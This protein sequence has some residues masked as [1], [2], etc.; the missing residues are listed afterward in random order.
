V[1]PTGVTPA[2]PGAE[3]STVEMC[4]GTA[5]ELVRLSAGT[6]T[7]SVLSFGATLVGLEASGADGEPGNC[8][9][10]LA[11]LGQLADPAVNPHLCG[12]VGPYA[13]RIAGASFDLDGVT[14]PLEANEGP[15]T[16]HGG[17]TPWDRR[18]W[19]IASLHAGDTEV[20][21]TLTLIDP[22]G[23]GGFPGRVEAT[24]TYS[25]AAGTLTLQ[26]V[27]TTDRATVLA[28]TNHTYWNLS[29][30]G[31][32]ADHRVSLSADL[33][34]ES[35]PGQIPTG[36]ALSVAGGPWD[37]R[38]DVRLGDRLG[39]PELADL[40]GY[41]HTFLRRTPPPT[42]RAS[43]RWW[44]AWST[45]AVAGR[46]RCAATSRRCRCTPPTTSTVCPANTDRWFA[47]VRVCLE[48]GQVP[49][50]PKHG[51][52]HGARRFDP[53]STSPSARTT[54]T[55]GPPAGNLAWTPTN[56]WR[57]SPIGDRPMTGRTGATFRSELE[58]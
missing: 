28:P 2:A 44:P 51:D 11:D 8:V 57:K 7:A 14:Y 30:F 15:N 40:D 42:S 48:A 31:T 3:R 29:G 54:P 56:R 18:P 39:S 1:S 17:S 22:D 4:D 25:L 6:L 33:M 45:R 23:E 46:W 53:L 49:N 21:V 58:R 55:A 36:K 47:T 12:I 9:L 19:E 24:A 20:S 35:G 38:N 27:G 26:I 34:L 5:A 13:N 52:D 43:C 41:D 16:L 32:I 50:G 37:L 10:T